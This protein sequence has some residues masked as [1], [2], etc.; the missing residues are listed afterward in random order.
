MDPEFFSK[1]ETNWTLCGPNSLFGLEGFEI[2][3]NAIKKVDTLRHHYSKGEKTTLEEYI[4]LFTDSIYGKD[5]HRLF[6][7][8]FKFYRNN[9]CF[10]FTNLLVK[11]GNKN[12]FKYI[13]SYK[14]IVIF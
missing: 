12:V 6:S 1:Y 14:G 13:F 10:R 8:V 3:K 9:Y 7:K 2:D 5:T 4:D 11:N